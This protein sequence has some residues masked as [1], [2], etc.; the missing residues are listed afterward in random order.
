MTTSEI[1]GA[2]ELPIDILTFNNKIKQV[3]QYSGKRIIGNKIKPESAQRYSHRVIQ[4]VNI[5]EE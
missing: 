3:L 4:R 1:D 5:K 2:H